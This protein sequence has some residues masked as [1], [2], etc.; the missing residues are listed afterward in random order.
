VKCAASSGTITADQVSQLISQSLALRVHD[1]ARRRL[2]EPRNAAKPDV[3]LALDDDTTVDEHFHLALTEQFAE[4]VVQC[5]IGDIWPASVSERGQDE[6]ERRAF[7][8]SFDPRAITPGA[9]NAVFA[10]QSRGTV[11]ALALAVRREAFTA[12]GG[13]DPALRGAAARADLVTRILREGGTVVHDPRALCLRRGRSRCDAFTRNFDYAA[14][15]AKYFNDAELANLSFAAWRTMMRQALAALDL[16]S[17]AGAILGLREYRRARRQ[18]R[19]RPARR[20]A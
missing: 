5:V 14:Y 4:P 17:A 20:A 16:S 2:F 1:A 6:F 18:L 8:R 11:P 7:A 10:R 19:P 15:C 9:W 3:V 12:L 13:F